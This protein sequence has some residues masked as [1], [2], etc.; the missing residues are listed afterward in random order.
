MQGFGHTRLPP[1]SAELTAPPSLWGR[2]SLGDDR[3]GRPYARYGTAHRPSPTWK[4]K[5]S[6]YCSGLLIRS[7]R[8]G[9]RRFEPCL[10][11]QCPFADGGDPA[12]VLAFQSAGRCS[13]ACAVFTPAVGTMVLPGRYSRAARGFLHLKPGSIPGSRGICFGVNQKGKGVSQCFA[14]C[15]LSR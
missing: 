1:Q 15:F 14:C 5:H 12:A 13:G 6:W 11:R 9:R 2:G 4:S 10:F 3:K 8:L 7:A